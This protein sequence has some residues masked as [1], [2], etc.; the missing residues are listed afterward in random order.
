MGEAKRRKAAGE[1][2]SP[3]R[4]CTLCCSVLEIEALDKPMYRPCRHLAGSACGIYGRPERPAVCAEFRCLHVVLR[5]AG[6][7]ERNA[8][9]HPSD[10]GAYLAKEPGRSLI[11]LF[12][13]PAKPERWKS[14]GLV[15][16]LRPLM[17]RGFALD[18][19]DRGRRMEIASPALFEEVLKLDYVAYADRQGRPLDYP[20]Y[21][22]VH[23]AG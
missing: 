1:P 6:G 3:C 15:D 11:T 8:I 9:P 10:A 13:D 14:S 23:P 4:T 12:V 5:E 21:R 19:I 22:E 17:R 7:S 16:Y 18:V 20:S 2:V